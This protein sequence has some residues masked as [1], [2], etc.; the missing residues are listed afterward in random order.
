MGERACFQCRT[1]R[2]SNSKSRALPSPR[3]GVSLSATR[4]RLCQYRSCERQDME[5]TVGVTTKRTAN[6]HILNHSSYPGALPWSQHHS[7]TVAARHARLC[8]RAVQGRD[9]SSR[10]R[11]A[12]SFLL[13]QLVK[14]PCKSVKHRISGSMHK[15]GECAATHILATRR[16][17]RPAILPPMRAAASAPAIWAPCH[18][19]VT[20]EWPH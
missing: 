17:S 18:D 5:E 16:P 7:V 3:E 6:R 1:S 20:S 19:F 15:V 11:R 4:A 13:E 14:V 2:R 12:R 8:L 9:A 10:W